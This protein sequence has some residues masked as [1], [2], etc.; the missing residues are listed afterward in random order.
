MLVQ[1]RTVGPPRT[2]S[3]VG[4]ALVW[5]A[6]ARKHAAKAMGYLAVLVRHVAL[7]LPIGRSTPD[8]DVAGSSAGEALW[9]RCPDLA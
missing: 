4:E 7:G 5:L 6:V 1:R 2:T 3:L 9:L 8:R